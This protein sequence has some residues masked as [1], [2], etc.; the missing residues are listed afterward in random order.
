MLIVLRCLSCNQVFQVP[1]EYNGYI[2]ERCPHCQNEVERV[3]EEAIHN[4]TDRAEF[5]S[6]HLR[7]VK[8]IKLTA[9]DS[10]WNTALPGQ[11]SCFQVDIEALNTIYKGASSDVKKQM[12]CIIDKVFLLIH[13][14]AKLGKINKL[15]QLY[16]SL[17]NMH[18]KRIEEENEEMR[19]LLD[20]D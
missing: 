19:R 10:D 4:M 1:F 8:L 15:K 14:D 3:D 6:K 20:G 2:V 13:D 18:N 5:F 9:D 12:E 17:N 11:K 7:T 16:D